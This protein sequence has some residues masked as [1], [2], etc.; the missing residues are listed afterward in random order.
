M[1]VVVQIPCAACGAANRVPEE[2]LGDVPVCGR[3]RERL[4]R[5][6]PVELDDASFERFVSRSDL[7]G[8][9]DF[10]A[11]SLAAHPAAHP[12]GTS[13]GSSRPCRRH[14]IESSQV[15]ARARNL[16]LDSA[17]LVPRRQPS[18]VGAEE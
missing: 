18:K 16:P 8:L 13:S 2:R 17:T 3:C 1:P 7:P 6:H 9:V 4:F 15:R 11:T 5:E 10:W 14:P 12:A